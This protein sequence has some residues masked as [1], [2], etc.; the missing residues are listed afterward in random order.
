[1]VG[2]DLEGLQ[3]ATITLTGG[4]V[5]GFQFRTV[6]LAER[7]ALGG[8]GGGVNLIAGPSSAVQAGVASTSSSTTPD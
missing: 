1:M 4:V 7:I 5:R 2:G 3:A 6:N 8:Q